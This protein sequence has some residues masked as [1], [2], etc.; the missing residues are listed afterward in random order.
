MPAQQTP[1]EL[2][3]EVVE[4]STTASQKHEAAR[5]AFAAT[6]LSG[7][8]WQLIRDVLVFQ[9][10]LFVDGLRDLILSPMSIVAALAGLLGRGDEPRRHYD[11]VIRMGRRSEHW[12]NLFGS[13]FPGDSDDAGEAP[14]G[15]IDAV[16]E[17]I[18]STLRQQ[19]E[20]GGVTR[21]AKEQIDSV[22]D[23]LQR[24]PKPD[25]APGATGDEVGATTKPRATTE[26]PSGRAADDAGAEPPLQH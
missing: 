21:V 24:K 23:S 3:G 19:H 15:G 16:F 22:L 4:T 14:A 12:I 26:P 5:V 25:A 20:G 13:H 1:E 8:R 17:R 7:K 2:D 18:E 10:K 9:A 6:N 11:E